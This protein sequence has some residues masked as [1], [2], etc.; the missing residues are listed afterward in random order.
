MADDDQ[1][2]FVGGQR[3]D[4]LVD[5]VDVEAV[6]RLVEDDEVRC[7]VGEQ[8]ARERHAEALP[9]GQPG[10]LPLHETTPE[11]E[12]GERGPYLLR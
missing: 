5:A 4:E 3:I 1:G 11:E 6:G 2:P 7:R 10:H 12:A 8:D 9:S